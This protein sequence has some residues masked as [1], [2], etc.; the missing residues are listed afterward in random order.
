MKIFLILIF[1]L[2]QISLV[3]ARVSSLTSFNRGERGMV[4][5]LAEYVYM[6]FDHDE[7]YATYKSGHSGTGEKEIALLEAK[8]EL[9]TNKL[10]NYQDNAWTKKTFYYL[11]EYYFNQT[12][13]GAVA[14]YRLNLSGGYPVLEIN[15][16]FRGTEDGYDWL[17][18]GRIYLNDID[19]E[20]SLCGNK[21]VPGRVH[22]GF[23]QAYSG[24]EA[25]ITEFFKEI[26]NQYPEAF[27]QINLTG[28]S[29]GAALASVSAVH[30]SCLLERDLVVNRNIIRL[31]T[32][33][34]PRVL[35]NE[36]KAYLESTI[37]KD[38]ILRFVNYGKDNKADFVTTIPYAIAYVATFNPIGHECKLHP[39]DPKYY[40]GFAKEKH[41]TF[42]TPHPIEGYLS[43]Y[44][45]EGKCSNK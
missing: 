16:G 40:I 17:Q 1:I 19:D 31:T 33:G 39:V 3:N 38:N 24:L 13:V 10:E 25:Q 11:K 22:Q 34:S 8:L 32:F 42:S 45:K 35:N 20:T 18:N 21:K 12:T 30:L 2:S 28:H 26:K 36:A 7:N 14:F 37:D 41:N 29:L 4:A 44:F 9:Y 23:L 5:E 6:I 43:E 27:L 15:I